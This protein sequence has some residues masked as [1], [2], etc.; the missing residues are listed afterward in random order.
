MSGIG[1]EDGDDFRY[2]CPA[3]GDIPSSGG[4]FIGWRIWH[5]DCLI[6]DTI[7]GIKIGRYTDEDVDER[8]KSCDASSRN[9]IE[10]GV[11]RKEVPVVKSQEELLEEFNKAI[12]EPMKDE[13]EVV[14]DIQTE[15]E[16]PPKIESGSEVAEIHKEPSSEQ[17]T[18]IIE[19]IQKV[20]TLPK[21]ETELRKLHI[22]EK[23]V[24]APTIEKSPI[25]QKIEPTQKI[26][27]TR[28]AIN[29][30]GNRDGLREILVEEMAENLKIFRDLATRD[31]EYAK[32]Y[33]ELLKVAREML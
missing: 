9:K 16:E 10:I 12:E 6:N 7:E 24:K 27:S 11:G 30:T 20:E 5:T 2:D 25:K 3:C 1:Q 31:I 4:T 21:K 17:E 8:L 23:V 14:D 28:P 32:I 19:T 26:E 18:T 15:I 33:L 22:K 13:E 29:L